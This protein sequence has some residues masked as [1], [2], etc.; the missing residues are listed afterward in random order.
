[1]T[2]SPHWEVLGIEPTDDRDRIRRAYTRKLK[3]TNP[4]DDPAGFQR[5]RAAYE[6][7]L[8]FVEFG[9]A[10]ETPDEI[11]ELVPL[12][13]VETLSQPPAPLAPPPPD[14][15]AVSPEVRQVYEDYNTLRE[16]LERDDPG[17]AAL[18][19]FA[20][21]AASKALDDVSLRLELERSLA[22]LVVHHVPKSSE[23][24]L[25]AAHAFGWFKQ[26]SRTAVS[27]VIRTAAKCAEDLAFVR[28]LQ[29][30]GHSLSAAY[31]AL[32]ARPKGWLLRPKII[33]LGLGAEVRSLLA[34]LQF[35]RPYAHA[36]LNEA[37]VAW[38]TNY[39][40]KPRLSRVLVILSVLVPLLTAYITYAPLEWPGH[41]VHNA[42]I[43][44]AL[45]MLAATVGKL[46]VFDW[47]HI[48]FHNRFERAAPTWVLLGWLPISLLLA[49]VAGLGVPLWPLSAL[50][51]IWA[52]YSR[53]A[54]VHAQSSPSA[55]LLIYI[56]LP[57]SV[58]MGLLWAALSWSLALVFA[59][60]AAAHVVGQSPLANYWL[61]EISPRVRIKAVAALL[62]FVLLLGVAL[63]VN[64]Q[65]QK[66]Y[67]P[68]AA[69]AVVA[70]LLQ[71][72]A[73]SVLTPGQ[74]QTR[75]YISWVSV[76][77]FGIGLANLEGAG[78]AVVLLGTWFLFGSAVGLV[79]ALNNEI[80]SASLLRGKG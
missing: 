15:A 71:R 29:T 78:I 70:L 4:E 36:G 30:G 58:W 24:V 77:A 44:A 41:R 34:I 55:A 8:R 46:L 51:V 48:Y 52:G 31:R 11:E 53:P 17:A 43:V 23:L 68:F 73:I 6:A 74:L 39:F 45:F 10:R 50:C 2:A 37:A 75:Y 57:L 64:A 28:E 38:W 12:E 27:P 67:P 25:R 35:E 63:V 20:R 7:A 66:L 60:A 22:G 14:A 59:F 40:A 16:L 42:T 5:L 3:T 76:F 19:A 1:M 26:Q 61:T 79:M 9:I 69:L 56:N 47:G 62:I 72:T 33:L 32:T 54:A 18:Q 13:D 21:I 49:V 80:R 65:D